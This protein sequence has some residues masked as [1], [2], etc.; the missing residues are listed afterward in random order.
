MSKELEVQELY[1]KVEYK[2]RLED[3]KGKGLRTRWREFMRFYFK[4]NR[5]VHD[6]LFDDEVQCMIDNPENYSKNGKR[7]DHRFNWEKLEVELKAY[8]K[9]R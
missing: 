3:F 9:Q 6:V 1:N 2:M 7:V 4:I 8:L 5:K